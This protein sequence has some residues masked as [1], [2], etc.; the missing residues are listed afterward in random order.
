M[1]FPSATQQPASSVKVTPLK[2]QQAGVPAAVVKQVEDYQKLEETVKR[3]KE[4]GVDTTGIEREL[5]LR[6]KRLKDL[7]LVN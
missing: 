4:A 1:T 6:Y 2:L 7:G 3:M 5:N